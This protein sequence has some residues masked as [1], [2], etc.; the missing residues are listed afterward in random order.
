MKKTYLL[1]AMLMVSGFVC[2]QDD[3]TVMTINGQPV[4]RSEFEYSY[5]KNNTEGVIDKK[6]I[7]EYVCLLYT[8][9][10]ADDMMAG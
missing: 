5:N 8:S 10:A 7:D 1:A 4:S 6:T 3:P 2:A 9:D